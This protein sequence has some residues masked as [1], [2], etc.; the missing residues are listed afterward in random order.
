MNAD[1]D[2]LK[3]AKGFK[4]DRNSMAWMPEE[5][6]TTTGAPSAPPAQQRNR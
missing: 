2:S 5:T 6:P 3:N 4:Y 1:K